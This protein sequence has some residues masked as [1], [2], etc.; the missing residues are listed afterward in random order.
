MDERDMTCSL[1]IVTSVINYANAP[2]S[3]S[4]ERSIFSPYERALQTIQTIQ[5]VRRYIPDVLICLIEGG[6]EERLPL[7]IKDK[8]DTYLYLGHNSLVRWAVDSPH[9]GLGEAAMLVYAAKYLNRNGAFFYK[10]SGRYQLNS[11]FD[12]LEWRRSGFTFKADRGGFSTRFYG[13]SKDCFNDWLRTL[14]LCI[15]FLFT[16]RSIESVLPWFVPSVKVHTCSQI[17]VEG[18]IGP[19]GLRF[20]E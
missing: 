8:V 19:Y 1:V 7:A 14:W 3:Y 6:H 5:S 11:L 10:I 12:I 18:Q 4:K 20:Q 2:L 9:K 16:R 13:F 17:G 15:P